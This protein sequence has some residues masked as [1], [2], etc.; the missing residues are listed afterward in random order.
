VVALQLLEDGS[1]N[2]TVANDPAQKRGILSVSPFDVSRHSFRQL[3]DQ[4]YRTRFPHTASFLSVSAKIILRDSC[5]VNAA[6]GLCNQ[7]MRV[8][9]EATIAD[10]SI[11]AAGDRGKRATRSPMTDR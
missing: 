8:V 4:L 1:S 10:T 5:G 11:G 2:E 3:D 9:S 6:H 7:E